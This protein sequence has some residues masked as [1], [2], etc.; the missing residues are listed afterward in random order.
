[1]RDRDEGG[2]VALLVAMLMVVMIGISSLAIDIGM[3]RVSRRDMQALADVVALD[4]AR[5]LDGRTVAMLSADP[6]W[7]VELDHSVARN[8]DTFGEPRVSFE[9]GTVDAITGAFLPKEGSYVPDAVRIAAA[10]T[11][12]YAIHQ[13]SGDV[14]RK[15]VGKATKSAC[16]K[17][18]SWAANLDTTKSELL[19][20]ILGE[21]LQGSALNLTLVGYQGLATADVTLLDLAAELGVGT[22]DE[23]LDT[24]VSLGDLLEATA[25][26]LNDNSDTVNASLLNSIRTQITNTLLVDV[27]IGDLLHVTKGYD[28]ALS[29][30]FNVLDL[31][32]GAV[33]VANGQHL[34]EVDDLTVDA[35]F[36]GSAEL[37]LT[38]IEAA[39]QACGAIGD[40][41]ASTSQIDLGVDAELLGLPSILG[42]TASGRL[43]L[44]LEFAKAEGV[45]QDVNCASSGSPD[46]GVTVEVG[47]YLTGIHLSIPIELSGLLGLRVDVS[48]SL[49]TNKPITE[50]EVTVTV[51]PPY[52]SYDDPVSTSSGSLGLIGMTP[53]VNATI[54]A[55]GLSLGL[56][57]GAI[58]SAVRSLIVTPLLTTVESSLLP[59]L[60]GLLGLSV[61]GADVFA[62]PRPS[63]STPVLAG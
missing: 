32:A 52:S 35:G 39:R 8:D 33:F 60:Q 42:L 34:L 59:T 3:Q 14:M 55:G 1:M 4:M 27:T 31:L 16:F 29:S 45:L 46:E 17:L 56:S 53:G 48:V 51:M 43:E 13:G 19:N 6:N 62:V 25:N 20:G 41:K 49:D 40:A 50:R 15:A 44:D 24:T 57:L 18:G 22:V 2:A 23:L 28:A 63:C 11:I 21:A 58:E 37:D 47:S 38:V 61:A 10:S 5:E 7:Q 12:D 30:S 36:L 9:L 26:V 54:A